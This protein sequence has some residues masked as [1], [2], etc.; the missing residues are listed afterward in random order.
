MVPD[1]KCWMLSHFLNLS[2][3]VSRHVCPRVSVIKIGLFLGG[4]GVICGIL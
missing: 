1:V 4:H 2:L 3:D